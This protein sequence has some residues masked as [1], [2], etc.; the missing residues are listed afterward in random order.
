MILFYLLLSLTFAQIETNEIACGTKLTCKFQTIGIA[1][2]SYRQLTITGSGDMYDLQTLEKSNWS[3]LVSSITTI[4]F[5]PLI[6]G[7]ESTITSISAGAF[8]GCIELTLVSFPKTLKS[9]GNNAFAHCTSLVLVNFNDNLETIGE[10][11]FIETGITSITIPNSVKTIGKSAF[12]NCP[13]I[14]SITFGQQVQLKQNVLDGC[15]SLKTISVNKNNTNI[16][17]ANNVLMSFDRK[18]I[19]TYPMTLETQCIEIEQTV[20]NIVAKAFYKNVNITSI[21]IKGEMKVIEDEAFAECT[22]LEEL[23]Y[24]GKTNPSFGNNVFKSATQLTQVKVNKEYQGNDFNSLPISKTLSTTDLQETI[25][26]VTKLERMEDFVCIKICQEINGVYYNETTGK[27]ECLSDLYQRETTE[28][29]IFKCDTPNHYVPNS[30]NNGCVC[31]KN[32]KEETNNNNKTQCIYQCDT[33]NHELVNKNND[34]CYCEDKYQYNKQNKCEYICDTSKY[35]VANKT[36]NGCECMSRYKQISKENEE[37]QCQYDCEGFGTTN[38]TNNGCVCNDKYQW[39]E[40]Q[41]KCVFICD[42]IN[43]YVP[44]VN[45]TKCVCDSKYEQMTK[46]NK[47]LCVYKCDSKNHEIVNPTNNGCM[48]EQKYSY[49]LLKRCKY[50]CNTYNH[51]E[52]N[53]DNNGCVCE[54]GY[55]EKTVNNVKKCVYQCDESKHEIATEIEGECNCTSGYKKAD[56]KCVIYCGAGGYPNVLQ[57]SCNCY[58]DYYFNTK[59][60]MCELSCPRHEE[61]LHN[62][63]CVCKEGYERNEK[64]ECKRKTQDNSENKNNQSENNDGNQKDGCINVMFGL[65]IILMILVF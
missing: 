59:T 57:T 60:Q 50:I 51:Y 55:V 23:K 19:L 4:S 22:S 37:L 41:G 46:N 26:C 30:K 38:S 56:N 7:D 44:D 63:V 31:D 28:K 3:K 64:G 61:P 54:Q 16:I 29:C 34:G 43:H 52:T 35:H 58:D 17:S 2:Y 42:T 39:N 33:K 14:E 49:N 13:K 1:S 27:C 10:K 25:C 53:A 15:A 9:I 62:A 6:D 21:S 48:C 8:S 32:Y 65:I 24:Y 20:E 45:N 5:N 11:A 47:T 36:N 40:T 18:T 12:G